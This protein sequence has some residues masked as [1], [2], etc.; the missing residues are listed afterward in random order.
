MVLT[1]ADKLADGLAELICRPWS[2]IGRRVW[3]RLDDPR[4]A[5][6]EEAV[7]YGCIRASAA[8]D[9]TLTDL[10]VELER[11]FTFGSTAE[12]LEDDAAGMRH[13]I[14]V[15]AL[16][17]SSPVRHCAKGREIRW[18]VSRPCLQW[19]R[20]SRIRFSWS[21]ARF[22]VAESF[23]DAHFDC[24]IGT[25]RIGLTTGITGRLRR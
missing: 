10:L 3:I 12:P 21:A 6:L 23:A 17:A 7:L 16:S 25:G 22:V 15:T 4:D 20:T 11:P 24:T 13:R 5:T 14:D 2:P 18:L 9:G 1:F 19:R 8:P